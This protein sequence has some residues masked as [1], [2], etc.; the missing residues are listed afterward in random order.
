MNLPPYGLSLPCS[1]RR[2]IDGDTVVVS[3]PGSER[4]WRIRLLDCWAPELSTEAGQIAKRA[5]E[6]LVAD[7]DQLSVF[8]PAPANA[9]E[10]LSILTMG[11]VLGHVFLR[12]DQ[13]LSEAMVARGLAFK[14]KPRKQHA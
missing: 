10:P 12:T 9:V 6:E 7:A 2:V 13:T 1:V 5:A 8:I 4:Q 14:E 3:I 11:R